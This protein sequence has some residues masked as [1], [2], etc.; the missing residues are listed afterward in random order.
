M[1]RVDQ[2]FRDAERHLAELKAT[3]QS[4]GAP[5]RMCRFAARN[6]CNNPLVRRGRYDRLTG[7]VEWT[8]QHQYLMRAPNAL[9]G[10]EGALFQRAGATI[11][12]W[13]RADDT[14]WVLP[15]AFIFTPLLIVIAL[16]VVFGW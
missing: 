4:A 11:R 16:C 2:A 5:C 3:A 15:L 14:V 8:D 10:E 7:A 6:R 9:C 13:R 1:G 12:V